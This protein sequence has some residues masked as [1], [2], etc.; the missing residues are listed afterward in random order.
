[1][2]IAANMDVIKPF[3]P[4]EGTLCT[5]KSKYSLNPYTGCS[6]GCI[7]CYITS[8]IPNGFNCRPKKDLLNRIKKDMR[9]I[10]KMPISMS[11]S[12]DPYP[13]MEKKKNLTRGVLQLLCKYQH[14]TLVVTKSDIVV[15]DSDIL[16]E[17]PSS[18]M[19]TITTLKDAYKKLEPHAPPPRKRLQALKKLRKAGISCGI[20]LDPIIPR[21]SQDTKEVVESA[22]KAGALHITCSTFKPRPD[23]WK[24]FERAFPIIAKNTKELYFE[25]GERISGA[26]YLPKK[27][28]LN[29]LNQVKEYVEDAGM[30]F[31]V[32]REGL[33]LS[34]AKSC[35]GSHL[36]FTDIHKI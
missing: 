7:Y 17:M 28:R 26:R 22:E 13:P 11:N 14:P 4:W 30:T 34:S 8:Y 21:I 27:L 24:R 5:C 1:M 32:C 12:S 33:D 3:D 31:G 16:G 15:R 36:C 29:L 6:H 10:D 23:A 25:Q 18:V 20:R 35:D 2:D 9:R 19:F